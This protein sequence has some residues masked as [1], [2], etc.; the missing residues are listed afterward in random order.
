MSQDIQAKEKHM[1]YLSEAED[2]EQASLGAR[3]NS[4]QNIWVGKLGFRFL[5][6]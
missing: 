2:K 4:L 5:L 6:C 3:P 1:D